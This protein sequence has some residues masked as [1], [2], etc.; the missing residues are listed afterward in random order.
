[1]PAARVDGRAALDLDGIDAAFRAGGE[2]W[3]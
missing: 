3:C 2:L 1:V